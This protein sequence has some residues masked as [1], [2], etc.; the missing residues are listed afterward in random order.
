MRRVWLS[1][2]S[3]S[4]VLCAG[5]LLPAAD[6]ILVGAADPT[7]AVLPG[8]AS[9]YFVFATGRG[10]PIF[11][12]R[13]LVTWTRAGRV[14][15]AD[16]P[17][18]AAAA[19]PGARGIWA[20]DISFREGQWRLYY[21]VSTFGSQRSVIGLV[22]NQTLDPQDPEYR[23]VDQGLVLESHPG[24]DNF[25]AIDAACFVDQA[26]RHYLFWGSFWSGIKVVELDAE[27][28]KPRPG[29]QPLAVAA[30]AP[31]TDPPAIEAPFVIWREGHYYLFVSYDMC[32]DGARSTYKV[33]VGRADEACGP[34]RDRDGRAMVDGGGTL[35][36]ASYDRWRGPGHNAVLQTDRG[37]FLVHHT[38]DMHD[39]RAARVLQIRPVYWSPD[40]WPVV[41]EPVGGAGAE[42]SAETDAGEPTGAWEHRVNYG[43]AR[44]VEFLAD[45]TLRGTTNSGRWERQGNQL[46]LRWPH[47]DA[48][49][50]CWVD[51]LV[52]EP[53]GRSYIGRNQRGSV[54]QGVRRRG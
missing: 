1:F 4:F 22:T 24:V 17:A 11:Q 51:T 45:G 5:V 16:V 49:D 21:S 37:D 46:L 38:Y 10:I 48:P 34:Y 15:D 29:A 39:L 42:P 44:L 54:I 40:G 12:S 50:G 26:S 6:D 8:A 19:I 47:A 41:G 13:D 23:W 18:W 31:R 36:L 3:G 35:V 7:I 25:N 9:P 43:E 27:T 53:H 30:R 14:F 28:G 33:M 20:P 32:C 2:I 52:L